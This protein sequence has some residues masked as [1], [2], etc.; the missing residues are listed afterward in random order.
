VGIALNGDDGLRVWFDA[1][2]R[3]GSSSQRSISPRALPA[4]ESAWAIT[5]HRSQG[6]EYQS[7]AVVLPPDQ[8]NRILTRELLY[9]A[10]SRARSH[11]EIW[12]TDGSMCAALTRPVH[13]QGGLLDRLKS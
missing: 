1:S 7:V 4:H 2:H 10:V 5:V 3:D 6:S 12:S 11:A 8:T 9:T 13:R